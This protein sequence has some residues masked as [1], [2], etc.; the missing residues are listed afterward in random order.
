MGN[1]HAEIYTHTVNCDRKPNSFKQRLHLKSMSDGQ[2]YINILVKKSKYIQPW[3][4]TEWCMMLYYLPTHETV[5]K[6]RQTK[7]LIIP[8]TTKGPQL[9]IMYGC[10]A[11]VFYKCR[12]DK[13]NWRTGTSHRQH[14]SWY[15]PWKQNKRFFLCVIA[16]VLP[17]INFK[18]LPVKMNYKNILQ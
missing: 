4:E 16:V 7:W 18:G 5:H 17:K 13:Q 10:V 15:S 6:S 8:V 12:K 1:H 11:A 14:N 3:G 9:F 2:M